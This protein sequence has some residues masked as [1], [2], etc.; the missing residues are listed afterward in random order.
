MSRNCI[1][2]GY[3]AAIVAAACGALPFSRA[4]AS[5]DAVTIVPGSFTQGTVK[6]SLTGGTYANANAN[7]SSWPLITGGSSSLQY[8]INFENPDYNT[9][10]T[11]NVIAF[12]NGGGLTL[13]FATP[14]T[15]V[16]GQKDLGIFTAQAITGGYA[17]SDGGSLF[18]AY[19]E[20]TI[21]VSADGVNWYTLNGALVSSPTTYTATAY[22]LNAP[23][24]AYNFGTGAAAWNDGEGTS[25]ATLSALSVADYSIPMPDDTRFNS[26]SSTNAQRLA[27]TTDNST[28]DYNEM[29]GNS[30]GGNWIDISGSGL[31]KVDYVRLNGDANDPSNG[32][33]RLESVFAFSSLPSLTWDNAGAPGPGDGITWDVGVNNNWDNGSNTTAYNDGDSV[34]F[35][36]I[37]NGNFNVT[38]NTTVNPASVVVDNSRGNYTLSGSGSIAGSTSLSK[39]GSATATM[40]TVNT[41]S[42][43][44]TVI[45]GTLIIGAAGALP[46]NGPVTLAGGSMQLALNTGGETISSLW[47]C[48]GSTLDITN[49]HVIISDPGGSIDS[50]VESYLAAGYNGGNW[51]GTSPNG[52]IITSAPTGTTYGI[53]WADGSSSAISGISSGQLEI[54]YTLYGDTNLDGVVNSV[55]FGTLA[56]N[57]GTSGPNVGWAQGAFTY[58]NTV[59][60][61]DFGLLAANFGK[62]LGSAADAVTSADWAA[63]DAFAQANG[64]MSDL[65]QPESDGL[66]AIGA[67][68]ILARRRRQCLGTFGKMR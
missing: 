41:Y 68:G 14:I 24:M 60:G 38:L 31:A 32:G 5:I 39:Y 40:S 61:V 50:T 63:L 15:P 43:G 30:G 12:G 2:R 37:N 19:M 6:P 35:N 47:I 25:A 11:G 55:D 48:T 13:Q 21:L 64:L 17:G 27:L 28:A 46:A 45:G 51:N 26:P 67:L 44:T 36:D 42:G 53:G 4:A 58:N 20:A 29:F 65:P 22:P 59:N 9:S 49:N 23:T 18:N 8:P 3:C 62:S 34:D 1:R 66:F 54:K 57:F 16:A 10:A 33:V 52:S 7:L 56:A